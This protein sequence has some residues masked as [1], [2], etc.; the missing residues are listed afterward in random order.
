LSE[1]SGL[2]YQD[3]IKLPCNLAIK[4]WSVKRDLLEERNKAEEKAY[5]GQQDSQ[6][7]QMPNINSIMGQAKGMMPSIPSVGGIS[8]P[9]MG[10]F[11]R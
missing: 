7:S 9:S 3:L 8:M 5:K 1:N 4:L 10:S 6:Q 11:K 2:G